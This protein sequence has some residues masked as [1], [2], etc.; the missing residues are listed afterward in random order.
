M[1]VA[2]AV[3]IVPCRYHP[4]SFG[5]PSVRLYV[6]PIAALEKTIAER[7]PASDSDRKADAQTRLKEKCL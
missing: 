3:V 7:T 5:C 2:G 6:D 4:D 1:P